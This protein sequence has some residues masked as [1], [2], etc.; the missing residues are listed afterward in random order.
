MPVQGTHV[1]AAASWFSRIPAWTCLIAAAC[2]LLLG[3]LI[4]MRSKGRH[5]RRLTLAEREATL[6]QLVQWINQ[7]ERVS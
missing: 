4:G 3:M 6:E 1:A 5:S 7:P 2:L